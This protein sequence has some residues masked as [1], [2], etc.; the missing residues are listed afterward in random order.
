MYIKVNT[1]RMTTIEELYEFAETV[2]CVSVE[3][4]KRNKLSEMKISTDIFRRIRDISVEDGMTLSEFQRDWIL[5]GPLVDDELE[6]GTID[7]PDKLLIKEK[8]ENMSLQIRKIDEEGKIEIPK[9]VRE[10]LY[11]NEGNS[12]VVTFDKDSKSVTF[13]YAPDNIFI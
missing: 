10:W 5:R 4:T 9:E 11:L 12:M 7:I 2:L 1:A 8:P 13:R 6:E 3:K